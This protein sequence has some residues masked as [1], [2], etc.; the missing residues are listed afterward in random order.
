MPQGTIS[1]LR[2]DTGL[3]GEGLEDGAARYYLWPSPEGCFMLLVPGS[4]G[5]EKQ[6]GNTIS[7]GR[8]KAVLSREAWA[9]GP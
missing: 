2:S 3:Y 5:L 6:L 1:A 8:R 9:T 7:G 4:L